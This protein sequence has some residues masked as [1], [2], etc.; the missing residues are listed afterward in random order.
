MHRRPQ[1][2][3]TLDGVIYSR[4]VMPLCTDVRIFQTQ[5][6]DFTPRISPISSCLQ[7]PAVAIPR[8]NLHVK[9]ATER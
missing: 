8:L 7:V 1:R 2:I 4:S 9:S 5:D 3:W 6:N